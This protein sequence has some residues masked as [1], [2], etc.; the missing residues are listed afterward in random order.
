MTKL[1]M[2]QLKHNLRIIS[3]HLTTA[4]NLLEE[5]SQDLD[6]AVDY[7]NSPLTHL[8]EDVTRWAW[9]ASEIEG[10]IDDQRD[11]MEN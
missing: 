2:I 4:R 6:S 5:L 10:E 3:G 8:V 7:E 1:E 11:S 9:T